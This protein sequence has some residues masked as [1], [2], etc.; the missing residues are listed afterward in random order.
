MPAT[1]ATSDD[2]V[3]AWTLPS[4]ARLGSSVRS[5]GLFMQVRAQLP[6]QLQKALTV[7][8]GELS[9]RMPHD[10]ADDFAT[11]SV[12]VEKALVGIETRAVIPR[13]IEDILGISTTE[14]RRWLADGRLPSLGT[15]TMK[16]RGR[17][18]ITFHVF[19]PRVVEDI[20]DGNQV[21]A[22]REED[23]ERAAKKRRLAAWKT[24]LKRAGNKDDGQSDKLHGWAEFERDGPLRRS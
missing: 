21:D 10:A 17:G 18:T 12:I 15:R 9:L 5:K 8:A 4:V 1:P 22:W 14:R 13:E 20:L 11:A 19:D 23:A 3:R 2:L 16:L 24:R 6:R 7:K